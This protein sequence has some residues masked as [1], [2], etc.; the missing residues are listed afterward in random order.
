[1]SFPCLNKS[2]LKP[3]VGAEQVVLQRR[4]GGEG[5]ETPSRGIR[6]QQGGVALLQRGGSRYGRLDIYESL[7]EI[8]IYIGNRNKVSDPWKSELTN[9]ERG[10]AGMSFDVG[11][12]LDTSV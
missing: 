2:I 9:T 8:N 5:T 12:Q 10:K 3:L 4:V 1:M 11:L 6:V 7:D